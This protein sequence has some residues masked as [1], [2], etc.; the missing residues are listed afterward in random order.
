MGIPKSFPMKF[1]P[2][3]LVDAFD[4]SE[5]FPGACRQLSDLVFDPSN[6]EIVYCRPG[7]VSIAQFSSA[8]F[9]APT[10]VTLMGAV[11]PYVFGF[12]TTQRFPGFDEPF[13]FNTNGTFITV[14]NVLATNVPA[15]QSTLGDWTPPTIA[16]NGI[17][18]LMTHP[19]YSLSTDNA[20]FT[21]TIAGTTL[22]V[23]ALT[24]PLFPGMVVTGAGV[25]AN[26]YIQQSIT[27]MG[28]AGTYTLNVA[29]TA[30]GPEAMTAQG[31]V[32]FGLMDIST[33]TAPVW[34]G[35]NLG[36]NPLTTVPSCVANFNNRSYFG[37]ATNNALAFSDDLL[38]SRTN[39]TQQ[40]AIG[41]FTGITALAGLPIT[42][43]SSG[44]TQSLTAFKATSVWQVTGDFSSTLQPLA[45][46][47]LSLTTGCSSPRSVAQ[48]LWGLYFIS[49]YGPYFIDPLGTMRPLTHSVQDADPDVI[50]PF[51]NCTAFTRIA[52]AYAGNV[53]R[54]CVPSVIF[55]QGQ[56]Y[57]DYWF[58]ERTRR[59]TGPHSFRYDVAAQVGNNFVLASNANTGQLF[60]SQPAQTES[61][62][63]SDLNNPLIPALI[64]STFPKT[65]QMTQ[66]QVVEST[67]E[68]GGGD[69]EIVVAVSYQD[70]Q[71]NLLDVVDI[72]IPPPGELWGSIA[73]GGSGILWGSVAEGGS[74]D[75]WA[76]G[77]EIPHVYSVPWHQ[78]IVF[79]KVA[80][81]I[82][83]VAGTNIQIGAHHAR[84]QDT[85]YMNLTAANT[86]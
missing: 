35:G 6:P 67:Q 46:N 33:L 45:Q 24:G 13:M 38:I 28:V 39:A 18:V 50:L 7:V 48:S 71:G 86:P 27:G 42:T 34:Y 51:R 21:G 43:T 52:G 58:D 26:S 19:G 65:Q 64:S 9:N 75:L 47:F 85:G 49:S 22:T 56:G 15:T 60:L 1:V 69:V 20:S 17:Y 79:Q 11:G 3:G 77:I 16:Q 82:T 23:T 81:Y 68:L 59:W 5:K 53:Y 55:P 14:A 41:D 54:V 2:K 30:A 4:A 72:S 44:V 36:V 12:V 61:T 31:E 8:G 84:Y 76:S 37:F 25:T 66:K 83:G 78:P 70:E 74:G 32:A 63:F 57:Y 10:N 80:L 73:E 29:T 62:V 40:L